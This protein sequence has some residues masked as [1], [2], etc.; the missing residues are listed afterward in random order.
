LELEALAAREQL[1]L[2]RQ[3]KLRPVR[4][5]LVMMLLG[6]G[7][8]KRCESGIPCAQHAHDRR[9]ASPC[10]SVFIPGAWCH[11]NIRLA[12]RTS[13]RLEKAGRRGAGL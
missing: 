4:H 7:H 1:N 11:A 2:K 10:T 5:D 3:S 12:D 8:T 6:I 13:G 9:S